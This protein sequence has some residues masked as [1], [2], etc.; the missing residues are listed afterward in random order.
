MDT[1][2]FFILLFYFQTQTVH[3]VVLSKAQRALLT[4]IQEGLSNIDAAKMELQKKA[5]LPEL[6]SDAVSL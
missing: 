2:L 3:E 4:T 1:S 5:Q 6:G